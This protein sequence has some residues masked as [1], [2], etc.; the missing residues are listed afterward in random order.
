MIKDFQHRFFENSEADGAL[1][2]SPCARHYLSGFESTEGALLVTKDRAILFVDFRYT[3]AARRAVRSCEV[4]EVPSPEKGACEKALELGLQKMAIE[5]DGISLACAKR[6]AKFFTS[7]DRILFTDDQLEKTV[8][9]MRAV[10]T[11]SEIAKLQKAQD[12]TDLAF[13][14]ILAKIRPGVTEKEIA[15]EL[16]Y[17]MRRHGADGVSFDT[18][19]VSGEN[20]S[21]CHGVPSDRK[22]RSGDFVTMDYGALYD[23]YHADMT[24]TVAVGEIS[25]EQRHVYE[26]VLKAQLAGIAAVK[27][28]IP[29][30][31]V[32]KAARDL[33]EAEYPGNFGHGTGH[34]VGLMIHEEPRFSPTCCTI[35][36]SGMVLSVEPGIYLEG[37]F[38]VRIEDLVVITDSGCRILTHSPKDLIIL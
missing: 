21:M 10:K 7:H 3:E 17:A 27:A 36:Q 31:L 16:E 30:N 23:G 15:A 8:N 29:C 18:I 33:I 28:G 4:E 37:K 38:G 34:S 11:E 2:I 12:I 25:E 5:Y 19:V 22:I 13:T 26:L 6:L 24:R 20:G 35:S 32:D 9:T 14:D 1:L